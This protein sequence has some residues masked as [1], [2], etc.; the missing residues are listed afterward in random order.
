MKTKLILIAF[1]ISGINLL[2]AQDSTQAQIQSIKDEIAIIKKPVQTHFMLRGF[3]Q[4]GF[5]ASDENINFNMTSFNP[6]LLWRHGDRFLIEAELEMEYMSNQF[7][8]N[9]GY[10]NASYIVTK[11]LVVRAGKFLIPF[12]TFGERFH[13]SWVN[14]FASQPLGFGHDGIAPSGDLGI[15][16]R[17]GFQL[18]SS[19]LNYSLYAVNGPRIKDGTEEPEE[20]GML[21]FKNETENNNNKAI[22]TR[23]GI[24]PLSNSSLEIGLSAYYAAPGSSHSPFEGDPLNEDLNYENVTAML[25]AVDLSYVKIISPLMGIIDIKGQ[26]SLSNISNAVY[27]NPE[28]T[29]R[30]TFTNES[31][32]YYVQMA[33]RPALAENQIL[34]NFEIAGRYSAYTTPVG[35]LWADNKSQITVGL[36]YWLSWRTVIKANYQINE[37]SM[38]GGHGMS[39]MTGGNGSMFQL[40]I[41]AGF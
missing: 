19:K 33:Y 11:G 36:N 28:D 13:P 34:K 15:E 41:A 25:T 27:Y 18:G 31:S 7:E 40:H 38:S 6:V 3:T 8:I 24:L 21:M 17:G 2:Q 5:D 14:K 30:Y 20:A 22:G 1:F 35:S 9:L 23:I 26:Y 37:S 32:A 39:T 16:V 4:F 29:S 10:A 12:G